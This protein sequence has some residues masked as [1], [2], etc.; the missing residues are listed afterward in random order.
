MT[1]EIIP[2]RLGMANA[3]LLRGPSGY[4]LVDTGAPGAAGRILEAMIT[5]GLAP[6]GLR[7][8]LI[9]HGHIDHFGSAAE[10]REKTGAPIAVHQDDA[11]ALRQGV[12][13]PGSLHPTSW[14]IALGMRLG[15]GLWPP[16]PGLEPDILWRGEQRLDAY[17]I[18]GRVIPVPGHTRGAIAVLLDDGAALIGDLAIDLLGRRRP[19]KPIVAWDLAMNQESLR[20]LAALNPH[21]VYSGH[22]GPFAQL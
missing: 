3:F 14:V 16:I 11:E 17:G 9:T 19:G 1:T 15:G 13:A 4:I 6:E 21:P 5:H 12:H 2:I 8:I 20:R 18:A 10:M 22:G 7:L